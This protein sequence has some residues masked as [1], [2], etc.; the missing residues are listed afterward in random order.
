MMNLRANQNLA[1]ITDRLTLLKK[2]LLAGK[3]IPLNTYRLQLNK[4]F[5]FQQARSITAYL[6]SLGITHCYTSPYL[7]AGKDSPHGYDICDYTR[8]N[9]EIGGEEAYEAF[10]AELSRYSMGHILDFV[11]NHMGIASSENLWWQDVLKNGRCSPY[12]DFF[13][14]DWNPVKAELKGKILLPILGD[15]YGVVLERGELVLEMRDGD[16]SLKYFDYDIPINPR[17]APEVLA[18]NLDL[19]QKEMG[20]EDPYLTEFHSILTALKNLP[21]DPGADSGKIEERGREMDVSRKR[22]IRLTNECSRIRCH[23]RENLKIFN[24][25]PGRPESFDRLHRLLEGQVYRL[26]YWRT[27]AHEINYRR[28]FD[29]NHLAAIR[30]ELPKVFDETHTLILRLIGEGK[31]QGL[32][33]DHPDGLFDPAAYLERLQNAVLYEYVVRDGPWNG[34]D[35]ATLQKTIRQWRGEEKEQDPA[36]PVSRPLYIVVEKI[37]T[38][39]ESLPEK[40]SV[41]GTCGHDFL[42]DLNALF[43]DPSQER[44]FSRIYTRYTGVTAPFSEIVYQSKKVI[45]QTDLTSELNVLVRSLNLI[46]E[47]DRHCRDFTLNSLREALGEVVACFPLYRTYIDR[48]GYLPEDRETLENAIYRARRRN[49]ALEPTI[50]D[51]LKD[52]IFPPSKEELSET[53]L[54]KRQDFIMKFQQ[55]TGPV[56]GKGLED[57]AFYRYNR[58][59]SLN[60]VGGQPQR[61]GMSTSAFHARNQ[62]RQRNWPLTMI[63]TATHDH[64][65]GEDVRARLNA[66]SEVPDEWRKAIRRW[67][68]LNRSKRTLVDGKYAPD[69]NEE[70]LF[71]QTLVGVWPT[72][73][74]NPDQLEEM[75]HRLQTYM[76]KAIKEAKVH[77]SW[78]NP[79]DDY[80]AA[81]ENFIQRILTPSKTNRFMDSFLPFQKRIARLGVINSLAQVSIKL[82]SPG[83]PDT[84]QGRELWDLSLVDP[85]NRRPVDFDHQ[86]RLLREMD[87]LLTDPSPLDPVRRNATIAGMLDQWEDGRIKMFLTA[88]GLRLRKKHPDLFLKGDYLPLQVEGDRADH[89]VAF[90]RMH[91]GNTVIT[92]APRLVSGLMAPKGKWPVGPRAWGNTHI[93]LPSGLSGKEDFRDL[94]TRCSFSISSQDGPAKLPLNNIFQI[95][96]FSLLTDH[97]IT[98]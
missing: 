98:L 31:V 14:I 83:I 59:I 36:G 96:P 40:W 85:D 1:L 89:A 47:E 53:Q 26:S 35:P 48:R 3:N 24:G 22:L 91:E 4:G 72:Q 73:P 15:Q 66:L 75:K 29:I 37:L 8:I 50:F 84:Y 51:F 17:T 13:D 30:M 32:R 54:K 5:T 74:L 57:T 25:V 81:V 60:E 61:F 63:C 6:S 79:N 12:S 38:G 44:E 68:L 58:L 21:F 9:T 41:S 97:S 62:K 43:I 16:L 7:A 76:H 27:A 70:Y 45:M 93:L 78:I 34:V 10:T 49:P 55:F 95:L 80:D 64:K 65:R 67:S 39:T 87:P 94:L 18:H 23:I 2:R 33:L 88:C 11:P 92:V 28:F 90:A 52:T 56:Q 46:S 69:R 42:N 20:D 19:L 82:T 77:S 71:Y 86:M